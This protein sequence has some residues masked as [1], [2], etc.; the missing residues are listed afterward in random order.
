MTAN[1]IAEDQSGE[2]AVAIELETVIEELMDE[3]D[4]VASINVDHLATLERLTQIRI[5][6]FTGEANS[7][8]DYLDLFTS[9]HKIAIDRNDETLLVPFTVCAT[10]DGPTTWDSKGQTTI[11]MHEDVIR[12]HPISL[13][14]GLAYVQDKLEHPDE[15]SKDRLDQLDR[16]RNY[17][18]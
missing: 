4:Y 16:I 5:T 17:S 6:A 10:F 18:Q 12:A 2:P 14:N 11:Y 3:F 8:E 15:W 1:K 9:E 7:F 13:E